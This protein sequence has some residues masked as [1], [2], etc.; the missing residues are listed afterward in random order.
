MTVPLS[1]LTDT[2]NASGT[3]F[4]A[5]QMNVTNTAS[6]AGSKLIDLQVAGASRFNVGTTGAPLAAGG[7]NNV[8]LLDTADQVVTGGGNV[9]TLALTTGNVTI[10]CGARPIQSITNNGAYTITAPTNDGSCLL[11]VTN[12]A[13]AGATTFTGFSVGSNTGDALTTTNTQKFTIFIWRGNSIS[14]YRIAAHQ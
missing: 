6:A 14:G 2:W 1:N 13:S 5:I 7:T 4:A 10:D 9:T 11:V 12:G 8:A 3:V